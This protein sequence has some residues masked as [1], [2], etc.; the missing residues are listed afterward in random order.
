[1]AAQALFPKEK[2]EQ[3]LIAMIATSR[4][5]N[6]Y[7]KEHPLV[8]S[9]TSKLVADI[10]AMFTSQDKLSV[11]VVEEVLVFEGVPFYQANI[12]VREFQRR[13]EERGVTAV[14]FDRGLV[15]DEVISWAQF[16]I[17][18]AEVIRGKGATAYLKDKKVE[19]IKVRDVRE[20]Y[21]RTIDTVCE[22]LGDVRMGKIP[23][24]D[25]A[26]V[27]VADL[28]QYV[29]ND[30]PA[31]LAL[32]LLKSYDNYLFNHS[33]N[34]SVLSLTLAETLKVPENDLHTIGLAGL[35]HDIGKT[36]TPK[37]IILKPH[38]LSPE[39]W[40]IMK[41]HPV[42]SAEIV[43]KM[44]GL[45]ELTTR[46]VYEHHVNYD[47][48]GYPFLEDGRQVHPYSKIITISDVYDAITTLRPYQK[49]FSPREAMRIM[50]SLAGKVI[51]PVYYKEFVRVL[52][53]YPVG[54]L[55]RLDTGEVAV[56]VETHT[57]TPMLPKIRIIFDQTGKK[58]TQP[59]EV[60]L[61][62]AAPGNPERNL[63]APADPLLFDLDPTEFL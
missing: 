31:L 29:L 18:D 37:A 40:Q 1:V 35:L 30:K 61:S 63:V 59:L 8:V 7:P 23:S 26:K 49:P 3:I 21:N 16:L 10:T 22:I 58:L 5:L 43:A 11:A 4:N 53:I 32:T 19:H 62:N 48:K 9:Q 6:L 46:L 54:S 20:V 39:E 38:Q 45:N 24:A 27:A 13:I 14:E 34:V 60:D 41:E 56:V 36:M 33:V 12:A 44:K 50:E 52:G 17:E 55:V 2:L 47:R 51:D 57:E 28:T 42:K 15:P 25:K